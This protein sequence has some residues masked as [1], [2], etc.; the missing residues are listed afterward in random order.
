MMHRH[1]STRQGARHVGWGPDT[2]GI[3]SVANTGGATLWGTRANRSGAMTVTG[4]GS[5]AGYRKVVITRRTAG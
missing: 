3:G 1:R 5:G 4:S 2:A